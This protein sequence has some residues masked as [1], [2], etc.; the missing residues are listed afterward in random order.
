MKVG[1]KGFIGGLAGLWLTLA[2]G[3][4]AVAGED[5]EKL[6][7]SLGS[8]AEANTGTGGSMETPAEIPIPRP[9]TGVHTAAINQIAVTR[10][11]RLLTVSD[12]KTAR[13]WRMDALPPLAA[14]SNGPGGPATAG[15]SRVL[16]VPIGLRNEGKLYAAAV[17]P[18]KNRAVVAGSTGLDPQGNV[19]SVFY[20][21]DLDKGEMIARVPAVPGSVRVLTYS[22]DGRYIA[23]GSGS[24][25]LRV[26]DL[27]NKDKPTA[28]QDTAE[29]AC[30]AE[31]TAARFL[32][33]GQLVTA[34]QDGQLRLYDAAFHLTAQYRFPPSHRPWRLAVSPK[35][36]QL[37]VGSLD[38]AS[39]RLFELPDLKPLPPLAGNAKRQGTLSLVAWIG[40]SVYAAG[41]YGDSVRK[42]LRIW[43]TADG[44]AREFPVADDT[45]TDL[46][47]LPDGRLAYA[48]AEPAFGVIDP[49]G[50]PVRGH[51]RSIPDFRDAFE[52]AFALSEDGTVLDF[53]L[54]R[55]G[56]VPLR[57][58]LAG[59]TLTRNPPPRSDL[60]KPK[61]PPALKNWRN[62]SETR[63]DRTPVTL[64]QNERS[65]SAA[66]SADGGALIGAD[67]SLQFWKS[68]RQLWNVP[69]PGPAWA[70]VLSGNGKFAV[71]ALGDGTLR[72]YDRSDGKE[73]MALLVLDDDRW[74]AWNPE[75]YF[76][77]SDN[78]ASL[79][80]YH[81]NQH[82]EG[83]PAQ[84]R[85]VLSGQIHKRFF[86][87]DVLGAAILENG[88]TAAPAQAADAR[89]ILPKQ[90]APAVRLTAWCVRGQCTETP[91][92]TPEKLEVDSPEM[93]LRF[94]LTD[95]GS[96]IG[97]LVLRRKNATVAGRESGTVTAS[98]PAAAGVRI[99]ERTV[100]L[101]PGENPIA[102]TAFDGT[103]T[104]DA[105][106]AVH[107]SVHYRT[108]DSAEPNLLVVSVGID[109]Y[110]SPELNPLRN[111]ANDA[112]GIAERLALNPRGLFKEAK[113]TLLV[114]DKAR[115]ADIVEALRRVAR[116]ARPQD[117][118]VVF[119]AGHGITLE[120]SYYFLPHDV[121]I[122]A[123]L[124]DDVLKTSSLTQDKFADLLSDLAASRVAI[125]IDS[126]NS[127]AFA[128]PS[129]ILRKSQ[130]R[131]WSGA[132]GHD[133]GRF[134]LAGTKDEQEALDGVGGHGVFTTVL[135]EGLKGLAD[136]EVRGNHDNEVDVREI[137][138]YSSYKVPLLA[139][140][141]AKGHRQNVVSFFGGSLDTLFSLSR[142]EP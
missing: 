103:E 39:V 134:V 36:D 100:T 98:S 11:G 125:L 60:R 106:E 20:V 92:E 97:N 128:V 88:V 105:G 69:V 24:G 51:Q 62:S 126:C 85:F 37:A 57:F 23:I 25:W 3:F 31:V 47:S 56:R 68:G 6:P 104:V 91:A 119:L 83:K 14:N 79:I 121:R 7:G 108:P 18:V 42:F 10:D 110:A 136:K 94:A 32:A 120:K 65:L 133:T 113:T 34:C 21:F 102:A 19:I 78:A 1:R 122:G 70:V 87:P 107:L 131:T 64:D 16:R 95:Q 22:P 43:N 129:S 33:G 76:D 89:L 54:L 59:R 63:L 58:D 142:S 139:D 40:D 72:W 46:A 13:L 17:S 52:G 109:Q 93:T 130:D 49:S 90:R 115:L 15:P 81:L 61:V 5:R 71:A 55:K 96:G 75:G 8:P 27:V 67:Y 28:F 53:G 2:T 124:D 118:V 26:V 73:L 116:E 117:M 140:S 84:P 38:D 86:R 127:G 112:R 50:G 4:P 30:A 82:R 111:A 141:I 29:S 41:T 77:H 66:S 35:G 74:L 137:A 138:S 99:V 80:G 123:T 45:L 44:Q 132:L 12:D 9:E 135:L 48:T 101:E 114:N